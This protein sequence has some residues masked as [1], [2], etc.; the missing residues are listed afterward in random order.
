MSGTLHG[1][2]FAGRKVLL[3]VS[4]EGRVVH[5]SFLAVAGDATPFESTFDT[6]YTGFHLYRVE[7]RPEAGERLTDNNAG[8]VGADV[9]EAGR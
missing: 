9:Q 7:V 1:P 5:E 6:P 3:R 4:C 8:V 2:G